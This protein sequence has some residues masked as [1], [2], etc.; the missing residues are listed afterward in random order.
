[1]GKQQVESLTGPGSE[2]GRP[3]P[4]PSLH[5]SCPS[6]VCSSLPPLPGRQVPALG[7]LGGEG[8]RTAREPTALGRRGVAALCPFHHTLSF[9][10]EPETL[11]GAQLL[12]PKEGT[13]MES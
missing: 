11:L 4:A 3:H 9:R 6:G 10:M 7:L 2:K 13:W 5:R 12:A 1:M 8:R